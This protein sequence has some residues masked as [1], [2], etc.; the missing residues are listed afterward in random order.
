MM[1]LYV[2]LTM[3]Q[4]RGSD[5]DNHQPY[6]LNAPC[7]CAVASPQVVETLYSQFADLHTSCCVVLAANPVLRHPWSAGGNLRHLCRAQRL[8]CFQP[9]V[10]MYITVLLEF[11]NVNAHQQ[12]TVVL[13]VL[14]DT[15]LHHRDDLLNSILRAVL[16]TYFTT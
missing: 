8:V 14:H 11:L 2:L 3:A 5:G 9:F 7:F 10:T 16:W 6:T 15:I 13:H 1:T 4:V 12:R